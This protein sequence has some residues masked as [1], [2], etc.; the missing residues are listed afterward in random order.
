MSNR[1]APLT[2]QWWETNGLPP[3][4]IH[5]RGND[6]PL[7]RNPSL[8]LRAD[9]DLGVT[10]APPEQPVVGGT[11]KL[12]DSLFLADLRSLVPEETASPKQRPP[13]FSVEEQPWAD[14]LLQLNV[15]GDGFLRVQTPLFRGKVSTSMKLEGTLK[16]PLALGEVKIDSGSVT[17]PFGS[18]DVKQGLISLTSENRYQPRLYITAGAQRLGYDINMEV[19]GTAEQP[20]VQFSSTPPLNSEQIILMLTAGQ[21]PQG[22]GASTTARERAQGLALFVGKNL[23]SEFGF[24]TGGQDRLIVRSGERI[25]ESGHPTYEAEYKLTDTVSLVGQYDRF[26]QYNLNLKW[27]AYSK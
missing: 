11:V 24:G 20:A 7:V 25:S 21:V 16:S 13:Y 27:K 18:L 6:V 5:L 15:Q 22:I 2:G 4:E 17:F 3:F 14:W 26:D 19:T 10:N 9:L 8:L 12:R 23:L 1:G